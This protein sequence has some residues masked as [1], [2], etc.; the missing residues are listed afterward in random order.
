MTEPLSTLDTVRRFIFEPVPHHRALGLE[1]LACSPE[2]V[3][4]RL[5]Y[6]PDLVGDPVSGVLHGGVI[7]T[8][9][10]TTCGCAAFA[11]LPTPRRVATLDLRIDYMR[12]A[13][14]GHDVIAVAQC[15]RLT[16]QI[17]FVRAIAHDGDPD[18]PVASTAGTFAIFEGPSKAKMP[19]TETSS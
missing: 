8:L 14:A 12:P 3:T 6:R 13:Q 7:T 9:L 19:S 18:K 16:K 1:L 2:G 10:D 11:R 4:V 5:P 15:Y 17:A